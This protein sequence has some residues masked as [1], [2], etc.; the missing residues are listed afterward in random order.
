MPNAVIIT[1][2]ASPVATAAIAQEFAVSGWV[3]EVLL[4][5]AGHSPDSRFFAVGTPHAAEAAEAVLRYPGLMRSD[6]RIARRPLS[7]AE[8]SEL[9]LRTGAV[10]PYGWSL[11]A[12][13]TTRPHQKC[14]KP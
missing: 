14:V 2:G 10:R 6:R 13:R 11:E 7:P 9:R 1:K 4:M 3:V 8:L 5:P 12:S